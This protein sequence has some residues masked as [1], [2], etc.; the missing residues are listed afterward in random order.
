[1]V[2]AFAVNWPETRGVAG[3][4]DSARTGVL[5]K[6]IVFLNDMVVA[7]RDSIL[8]LVLVFIVVLMVFRR[9]SC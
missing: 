7:V 9:V 8:V 4:V 5:D 2:G 1:M 6:E 3:G